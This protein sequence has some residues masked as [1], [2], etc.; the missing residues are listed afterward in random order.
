[1][2]IYGSILSFMFDF[3]PTQNGA[4]VN[5][6]NRDNL[7][8]LE[9]VKD[10]DCDIADLL[11]GDAALLDAAKKGD[12]DRVKKLVTP[13]NINCRDEHGRNST[14]LHLAGMCVCVCTCSCRSL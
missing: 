8:P 14:P 4:D 12:L 13:E 7:T 2:T 3:L 1:M 5:R 9:M 6:R 11:R 10:Q